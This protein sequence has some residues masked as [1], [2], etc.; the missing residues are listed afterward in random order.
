MTSML[1]HSC[2]F[3]MDDTSEL[4]DMTRIVVFGSLFIYCA[5]GYDRRSPVT[6][7][8]RFC[9][10]PTHWRYDADSNSIVMRRIVYPF[11]Y[12]IVN[13]WMTTY[14]FIRC[15]EILCVISWFFV[16]IGFMALQS[17]LTMLIS[18]FLL[19]GFKMSVK[20]MTHR[21]LCI[22]YMCFGLLFSINN[23]GSWSVDYY[24]SHSTH[25]TSKFNIHRTGFGCKLCS[26][27]LIYSLFS[28]GVCKLYKN[29]F[30]WLNGNSLYYY[31]YCKRQ[32]HWLY[33][34]DTLKKPQYAF[35]F[36]ILAISSVVLELLSIVFLFLYCRL[37]CKMI[38]IVLFD[39]FHLG[40]WFLMFP[41]YLPQAICYIIMVPFS[42]G[43]SP[44]SSVDCT[45]IH[46]NNDAT[47]YILFGNTVIISLAVVYAFQIESYPFHVFPMYS[48]LRDISM[49]NKHKMQSQTIF[50]ILHA[51]AEKRRF[52]GFDPCYHFQVN[53]VS[54][55]LLVYDKK[56]HDRIIYKRRSSARG[57]GVVR[58]TR[59]R[60]ICDMLFE[61][62]LNDQLTFPMVLYE[63]K[64]T[65][66]MSL[67][68]SQYIVLNNPKLPHLEKY[69]KGAMQ[70]LQMK[71]RG[72]IIELFGLFGFP[73]QIVLDLSSNQREH[74]QLLKVTKQI[75]AKQARVN[76]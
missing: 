14:T 41:N 52:P 17:L 45:H 2:H 64:F 56:H 51:K 67:D 53:W 57:S 32:A 6:T 12:T 49:K 60:R 75:K 62:Y 15:L 34:Y 33:L 48:P 37:W 76:K 73:Y 28:A 72:D 1:S 39:A 20:G 38:F 55:T 18:F 13:R 36:A 10:V 63:G 25:D 42:S 24:I 4:D 59:K 5:L 69:L 66:S 31:I 46:M 54:I 35:V 27:F 26:L 19:Y 58:E 43:W 23:T 71:E 21:Y 61:L 30:E 74:A 70:V 16:I 40:I 68:Q 11:I 65:D 3:W 8:N 44:S 22:I 9:K 47:Y 29:G 50:Q 7:A